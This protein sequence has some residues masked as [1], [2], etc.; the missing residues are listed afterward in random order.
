MFGEDL[1]KDTFLQATEPLTI[2]YTSV[3]GKIEIWLS[4]TNPSNELVLKTG[5]TFVN[6]NSTNDIDGELSEQDLLILDDYL[7]QIQ[8]LKDETTETLAKARLKSDPIYKADLDAELQNTIN[9]MNP[10]DIGDGNYVIIQGADIDDST[11]SFAK[12]YSSQ[13]TENKINNIVDSAISG[14]SGFSDENFT[15]EE[16]EKLSTIEPNANF[17]ELTEVDANIVAENTEKNFVSVSEKSMFADKYTKSEIDNLLS[18][19]V[20]GLVWK[21]STG[22]IMFDD[23]V[24][25]Y[26]TPEPDWCVNTENEGTWLFN[27]DA[28]I[29]IN[30]DKT[31]LSTEEVNGLMTWLD[32][33]KL[34]SIEDGGK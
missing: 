9:N 29:K 16:K 4:I 13:T 27:G 34:N 17:F 20:T 23:I 24:T 33:K 11:A 25:K 2:M 22:I 1:Y 18:S 32:K 30:N 10:P 15:L 14:L 3:V 31:P 7:L 21:D 12:V 28:W 5:S 8:K 19:I 26:P 6:I